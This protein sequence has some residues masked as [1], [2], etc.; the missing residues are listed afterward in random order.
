MSEVTIQPLAPPPVPPPDPK[1]RPTVAPSE[2][3]QANT[4]KSPDHGGDDR[5][6]SPTADA[7]KDRSSTIVE[8]EVNARLKLRVQ[9][10]EPSGRYVYQ[11]ID[12]QTGEVKRQFPM[13]EALRAI[14]RMH[15]IAGLA[16]DKKL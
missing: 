1:E 6:P 14:A 13:E 16:V 10:D 2:E 3:A 4:D 15:D 7:G 5:L 12:P 11:S 9:L 8:V